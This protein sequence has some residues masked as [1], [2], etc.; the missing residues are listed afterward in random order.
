MQNLQT[1]KSGPT[2]V[3]PAKNMLFAMKKTGARGNI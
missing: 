1:L 2:W 3:L